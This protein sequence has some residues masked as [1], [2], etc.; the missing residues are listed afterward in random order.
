MW[1]QNESIRGDDKGKQEE[2]KEELGEE[3]ITIHQSIECFDAREMN[4]LLWEMDQYLES[5]NIV[6][7]TNNIK[8]VTSERYYGVMV[9]TGVQDL[10]T[11]IA[12][13]DALMDFAKRR[14]PS[15]PKDQRVNHEKGRVEKN[16]RAKVDN[17]QKPPTGKRYTSQSSRLAQESEPQQNVGS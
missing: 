7:D 15:M 12:H 17:A 16:V 2:L 11:V 13:A 6:D 3:I 14:E 1:Y 5:V 8:M 10:S 4:D 9:E